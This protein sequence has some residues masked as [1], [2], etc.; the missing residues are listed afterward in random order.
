MISNI[1]STSYR[2]IGGA[3]SPNGNYFYSSTN[4]YPSE[5]YQYDINSSN[6]F[7]SR[8]LVASVYA[9]TFVGGVLR[10]APDNKIY[11]SCAWN[12][13]IHYNYPYPDTAFNSTNMNLSVIQDPDLYGTNCSFSYFSFYL[14]GGRTYYGLPN[15]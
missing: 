11:W 4:N 13:S 15:N 7:A 2:Y 6:I 5:V 1:P 14:G 10:L 3:F 9:P 8:V 12:D